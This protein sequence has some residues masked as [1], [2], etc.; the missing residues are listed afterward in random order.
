MK[1]H[2][3]TP[4]YKKADEIFLAVKAVTDLFPEDNEHLSSLKS[5]LLGDAMIIPAKLSGAMSVKIYDIKMQNAVIIRKAAQDLFVAIHSLEMFGFKEIEYYEIVRNL[6]EEFR[7]LFINWVSDF[8]PKHFIV[9]K[10]GLL[11]P[12]GI[13]HD[14]IQSDDDLNFFNEDDIDDDDDF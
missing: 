9:D 6:I 7:L 5:Q 8:N 12:P 11:N 10:W 1:G 4:I 14:Y 3:E 13:S 2:R